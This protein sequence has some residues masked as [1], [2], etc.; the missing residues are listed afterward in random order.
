MISAFRKVQVKIENTFATADK[1]SDELSI[2]VYERIFQKFFN[3]KKGDIGKIF[4]I[5]INIENI[6]R[7]LGVFILNKSGST[8]FF[9]ELPPGT[10]FDHITLGKDI[11]T[12]NIHLT[13]IIDS[14]HKKVTRLKII[15]LSNNTYH[16]ITFIIQDLNLLKLAPKEV[17]FPP[18]DIEYIEL[19][20]DA[21]FTRGEQ[22]GSG[23]LEVIGAAGP[24]V[25]QVFLIPRGVDWTVMQFAKSPLGKFSEHFK[26]EVLNNVKKHIAHLGHEFQ[27]EYQFGLLA[28]RYPTKLNIPAYLGFGIDTSG[29]YFNSSDKQL[30]ST[31]IKKLSKK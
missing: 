18:V 22:N 28:F 20:K 15:P 9:P 7:I 13:H 26:I 4:P 11:T 24:V 25:I 8:S 17:I 2:T 23:V 5:Y 6:Y 1:N 10:F 31:V 16:L 27:T 14:K 3:K 30:N 21:F 12:N 19:V 29:A